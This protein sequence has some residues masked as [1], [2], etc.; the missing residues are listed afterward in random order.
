ML[1]CRAIGHGTKV[2]KVAI[3]ATAITSTST[4]RRMDGRVGAT[5]RG[6]NVAI[7]PP[8]V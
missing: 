4:R 2:Q 3:V 8:G 1:W 6:V 5:V 7:G